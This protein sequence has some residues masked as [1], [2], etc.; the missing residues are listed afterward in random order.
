MNLCAFFCSGHVEVVKLLLYYGANLN[1]AN[2]KGQA[3]LDIANK[4]GKRFNELSSFS[5][6]MNMFPTYFLY[7]FLFFSS[8][9]D[10]S[11]DK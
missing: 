3:P 1:A 5:I 10:H 2:S 8:K 4:K 11:F 9:R 7:F 6:S